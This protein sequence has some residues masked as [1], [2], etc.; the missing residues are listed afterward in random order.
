MFAPGLTLAYRPD[1]GLVIARWQREVTPAELQSGYL[2]I[3]AAAD[4]ARCGQWLLDLRRRED[5]IEPAVN[6]WFGREFAPALRGRY[7][8]AARLA[9]LVSPLRAQQPVAAMVSAAD[10]DCQ[11]ATFMDE[12]AAYEWLAS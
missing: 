8:R 12:A 9:F 2:A 7:E 1:L 11:L 3:R 4:E 5:V 10:A 6:T